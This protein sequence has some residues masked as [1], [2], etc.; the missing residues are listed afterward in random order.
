M[1]TNI[2]AL[3]LVVTPSSASAWGGDLA[4]D[5]VV[6]AY[7]AAGGI[8]AGVY[9]D[10]FQGTLMAFASVLVFLFTLQAGGGMEGISRTILAADPAFMGPFGHM[11]PLAALSSSSS[12][13]WAPWGSRT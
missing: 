3:G 2:L 5:G 12:S 1:A 13:G 7:S 4:G 6:L 10:V 11:G 8:I 9:T